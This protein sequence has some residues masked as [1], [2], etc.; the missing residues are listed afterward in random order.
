MGTWATAE[1]AAR[2]FDVAVFRF[3]RPRKFLNF[4]ETFDEAE[5]VFLAPDDIRFVS[6]EE[7]KEAKRAHRQ[8][9]DEKK[10]EAVVAALR[11]KHPELVEA[12]L[13]FWAKK[14][15]ETKPARNQAESGP[16]TAVKVEL[17]DESSAFEWDTDDSSEYDWDADE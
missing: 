1:L 16:S 15:A 5:A 8:L 14:E 17:S 12:E 7:E 13:A 10:S 11:E 3:G 4:S 2:A 6:R 9:D